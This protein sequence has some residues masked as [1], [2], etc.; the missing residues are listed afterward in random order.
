MADRAA[1]MR[2]VAA[3]LDL[4]AAGTVGLLDVIDGLHDGD[5]W[6]GRAA[7]ASRERLV[8]HGDGVVGVRR[9]LEGLVGDLEAAAIGLDQQAAALH[10]EAFFAQLREDEAA[11]RASE[12]AAAAAE[13]T[14]AAPVPAAAADR[15][16][17]P[18]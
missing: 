2:R 8:N 18:R 1:D 12:A 9:S 11:R 4:L 10:E 3:Q 17:G 6:R 13:E 15:M 5:T 7:S 14:V 16:G